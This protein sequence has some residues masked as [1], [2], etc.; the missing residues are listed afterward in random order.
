LHIPL[1]RAGIWFLALN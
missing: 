1:V